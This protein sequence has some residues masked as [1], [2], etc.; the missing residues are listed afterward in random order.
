M[1]KKTLNAYEL[2]EFHT[3]YHALYNFCTLDMSALYLDIL[4]DRLYTSP[5]GSTERRSAQ[6]VMYNILDT[7]VKLMAPILAFTSEE[8]WKFMPATKEKQKS[9][10]LSSL[11]CVKDE[12]IDNELATKW[13]LLISL[14]N[15]VTKALEKARADKLIGHSLDA[16]VEI[17]ANQALYK[18]LVPYADDL[19]AIFIVSAASLIET[20]KQGTYKSEN[21][22]G[23]S[24]TITQSTGNKCVRCWMHDISVGKESDHP[25]LCKRCSQVIKTITQP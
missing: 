5:A 11:P 16:S 1:I 19:K 3:I 25:E 6:T 13:G 9:V 4:K 18:N 12:W 23:L 15:E 14:R 7:I 20:E 24:I 17:Y 2:F 22:E 21:I 10:H 8:I